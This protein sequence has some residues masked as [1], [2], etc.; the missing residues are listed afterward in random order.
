MDG[1]FDKPADVFAIGLITLEIAG[2]FFLPDNGEQWQRLRSGNL[3]DVP[4]LTGSSDSQILRDENGDPLASSSSSSFNTSSTASSS[5][6]HQSELSDPPEFM[7]DP[8]HPHSLDS[9]VGWMLEPDPQARPTVQQVL[10]SGG[11]Q[12]VAQRRRA[13]ATVYEGRWGPAAYN[14]ERRHWGRD[15]PPDVEMEDV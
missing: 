4:S 11:L 2:N 13:G 3:S 5:A 10:A 7:H 12:W 9:L 6:R 14:G 15:H 1:R 8:L